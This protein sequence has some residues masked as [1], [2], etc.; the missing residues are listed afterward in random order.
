[1][2]QWVS[3]QWTP[4]NLLPVHRPKIDFHFDEI[5]S[6]SLMTMKLKYLTAVSQVRTKMKKKHI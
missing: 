2:L 5:K 3:Q 6:N 1:M 4:W